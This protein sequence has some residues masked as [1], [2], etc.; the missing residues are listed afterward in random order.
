MSHNPITTSNHIISSHKH[1]NQ[2]S[3]LQESLHISSSH[4]YEHIKTY[5]PPQSFPTQILYQLPSIPLPLK[6][7][8]SHHKHTYPTNSNYKSSMSTHYTH[9]KFQD[10]HFYRIEIASCHHSTSINLYYDYHLLKYIRN[11]HA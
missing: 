11:H 10:I 3:R 5:Y 9:K 7:C 8:S 4:T 6:T 2:S 1:L